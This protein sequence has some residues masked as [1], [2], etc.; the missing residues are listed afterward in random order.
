[1]EKPS[2]SPV[3]H[4]TG[5]RSFLY[6][7]PVPAL[8][9]GMYCLI[10]LSGIVSPYLMP[11][12]LKLIDSFARLMSDGTLTRHI[13]TSFRR[14]G[15]GFAA[16]LLTAIPL[17]GLFYFSPRYSRL[18]KGTVHFMQSIP[19]LAMVPLLILWFGIGEASKVVLII[20]AAFF[21]VFLNTISG[22]NQVSPELLEMGKTLELSSASAVVHILL[23]EALPTILT[24]MRIAFG[25]SWRALIGAE[26]IASSNGLGYMILDSQEMARTD[27]VVIGILT[28][29]ALGLLFDSLAFRLIRKIFPWIEEDGL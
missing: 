21:P 6:A 25:Y 26:M 4:S 27:Q 23:P 11:P 2:V 28:I 14:V 12:P 15:F 18:L 17:A 29:G 8:L 13:L 20:L 22:L 24:G 1:M 10:T 5:D 9:I 7:L 16:T 3:R 19:P